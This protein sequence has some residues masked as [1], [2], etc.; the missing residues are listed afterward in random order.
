M[1]WSQAA[2][3]GCR[4]GPP[5]RSSRP[6][7]CLGPD[8][9]GL[10]DVGLETESV[11]L[12]AE[13]TLAF[14][15]FTDA[16]TVDVDGLRRDAG[17]IGRLLAI[18]L[19]LTIL[20]GGLLGTLIF[21]ELP[22][23]TALLIGA[24][25]APTDAALGMAVVG[26]PAVPIRVRRV[27]NVESG[28]NDGIATPFVVLF[29]A[30]ATA[31]GGTGGG[32]LRM[33]WRDVIAV[34][35]RHRRRR[36]RRLPVEGGGPPE[37]TSEL[38][39]Q[40]AVVAL[41]LGS[42][43]V[44]LA[45]G[46]NGF[47]AA[48]VAGIT[49]GGVTGQRA[50]RRRAVRRGGRHP[51]VDRGL[52]GVRGR[53][54]RLAPAE[55]RRLPADPVRRRQPHGGPDAA[56][57]D[58]AHRRPARAATMLFIGWFGPRG[59][60]SIVFGIL[61]VD[62]LA[63]VGGP[64]ALLATT[65]TW[66]VL[67]SVILHGLTAGPLAAR[68][69]AWIDAHKDAG[70]GTIPELEGRPEPRPTSYVMDPAARQADPAGR[71]SL[72]APGEGPG[73]ATRS[74]ILS[75]PS[76]RLEHHLQQFRAGLPEPCEPGGPLAIE[77]TALTRLR[78]RSGF[79]AMRSSAAGNSPH[80]AA[81]PRSVSSRETAHWSGSSAAGTTFPTRTTVPP[82][83]T[84]SIASA[85]VAGIPTASN[86][87]SGPRP[88][89]SARSRSP[90]SWASAGMTSVAPI[91]VARASRLG[92]RSTT[93]IRSQ[94]AARNGATISS[95]MTPAPMTSV[96][97]DAAD[98]ARETAWRATASGSASAASTID[99]PGGTRW[100]IRAGT[101]TRSA[102]A[103]S[104]RYSPVA[105]PSTRRRSHRLIEAVD[106]EPARAAEDGAV[107]RDG[108]ARRPASDRRADAL[109]DAGRLVPHHQR[110]DPPSRAPVHA[111]DVAA[112]DP[113]RPD[114]DHG[115][116]VAGL[117]LGQVGDL[118]DAGRGQQERLHGVASRPSMSSRS[119]SGS[120]GSFTGRLSRWE[121]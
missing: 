24:I 19:T 38:S 112:A 20:A 59:L 6:G 51:A 73:G 23:A 16:S 85:T 114:R 31:A 81:V 92:L 18:G 101:T 57:R 11:K 12:L 55:L 68:Y 1:R 106:A 33:R 107:E 75:R 102:N 66:T 7:S 40:I 34:A 62:A 116:L 93:T 58:G 119:S 99:T 120:S 63:P 79:V 77:P 44:S 82:L 14:V 41:A 25:L 53:V 111:V 48:F 65:V 113:G 86:T 50:A 54:R 115:V 72:G 110:R 96:E 2:S 104:R 121:R 37:L 3:T 117:R 76:I 91:A 46:G 90:T 83:R 42:Y 39:R 49:F 43:L 95:P 10:V 17:L 22:L 71:R 98:G 100:R 4:S 97:P 52:G 47:I 89:V 108:V 84:D 67:L 69:G 13:I 60:A 26:N 103:P 45:L 109:D 87:T 70:D 61:A 35:C 32:H 56:G 36:H 74:R 80:D 21:P 15:L 28:L 94:P 9:L 30:L 5:L 105:T 64:A 8:G 78:R 29:I 118:E 88:S 27:L